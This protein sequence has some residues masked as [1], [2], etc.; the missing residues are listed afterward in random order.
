MRSK[1]KELVDAT[2]ALHNNRLQD[3]QSNKNNLVNDNA[4]SIEHIK[5]NTDSIDSN[6]KL[7]TGLYFVGSVLDILAGGVPVNIITTIPITYVLGKSN[8]NLA[9]GI[10]HHESK[11][12]ENNSS[13]DKIN[14]DVNNI[15][16]S[17]SK[18]NEMEDNLD[19]AVNHAIDLYALKLKE[20]SAWLNKIEQDEINIT[21]SISKLK[22]KEK[23]KLVRQLIL[24]EARKNNYY[25]KN[26][27]TE[28]D[29]QP[30][31][32]VAGIGIIGLTRSLLDPIRQRYT[33]VKVF[34]NETIRSYIDPDYYPLK[35]L[36]LRYAISNFEDLMTK[37]DLNNNTILHLACCDNEIESIETICQITK[38][39]ETDL[40]F[41]TNNDGLLPIHVAAAQ[42]HAKAIDA[43][44]QIQRDAG[45]DPWQL[46]AHCDNQNRNTALH[47]AVRNG[48]IEATQALIRLASDNVLELLF[49]KD[50]YDHT[51]LQYA[52][53]EDY[54]EIVNILTEAFQSQMTN[55]ALLKLIQQNPALFDINTENQAETVAILQEKI[56]TNGLQYLF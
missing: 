49:M 37:K 6:I 9:E 7:Q 38:K 3:L 10:K 8:E 28:I 2:R 4:Q 13:L 35:S 18:L 46:I 47:Y 43:L 5:K 25:Q 48:N 44:I 34:I 26:D 17:M 24:E 15:S 30:T 42:G 54:I 41:Q 40:I 51:A 27:I 22:L 19:K 52:Q 36:P 39:H 31:E 14:D 16:C 50:H 55:K 21:C 11:L 29:C 20:N 53:E 45:N 23:E 32:D 33:S 1:T 56:Q 12:K